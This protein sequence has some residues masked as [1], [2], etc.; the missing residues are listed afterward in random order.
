MVTN[1]NEPI[2]NYINKF[3]YHPSVKFLRKLGTCKPQKQH[4]KTILQEKVVK[5]ISEVFARYF[6]ENINFCIKI[7]VFPFE[8]KLAA[9][10]SVYKMKLKT[11]ED[12][13][14]PTSIL[15]NTSKDDER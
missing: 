8:L 2:L 7:S 6:H 14:K 12:I 4:S 9:V 5:E 3:K 1:D 10:T 11:S 15:P 13:Y